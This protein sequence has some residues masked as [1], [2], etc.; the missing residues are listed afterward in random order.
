M[1]ASKL[2]LLV[3]DADD[4][5]PTQTTW[6]LARAAHERGLD[7]WW[8][9]VADL[10]LLG[11]RLRAKA[12]QHC[13]ARAG[14]PPETR[15]LTLGAG[16]TVLA[17]TNPARD[18]ERS[19]LHRLA[20]SLLAA[21][22][23]DGVAVVND[24]RGLE[25]A[26]TKLYVERLPPPCRCTSLVTHD[27]GS[28]LAFSREVGGAVVLK[29]VVGTRG[30]GVFR[31]RAPEKDV[32]FRPAFEHLSSQGLVLLQPFLPGGTDGDVRVFLSNGRPLVVDGK[33]AAIRRRPP[34]NDFRSNLHVGGSAEVTELS[35][36]Q[37][38]TVEQ[39]GEVL[40]SD[41][42]V[43]AGLDLIDD[44]VIEVNVYSPGGL[45][46][47]QKLRRRPFAAAVIDQLFS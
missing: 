46:P 18:L 14:T 38:H 4:V 32:N 33:V 39:A 43:L 44:V 16:D 22:Q 42:L 26:Q 34:E 11:G 3:N 31:F 9:S 1:A 2:L 5:Q 23:A 13:N 27:V 10:E 24:P 29:P 37:L 41:G 47:A 17:R 45:Y 15:L 8:T 35:R 25:L 6:L 20:I 36:R 7:V 28:A 19:G 30:Q 12:T 21:A 40:R